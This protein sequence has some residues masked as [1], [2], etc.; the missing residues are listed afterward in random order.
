[1]IIG[2]HIYIYIY[3]YVCVGGFYRCMHTMWLHN[4]SNLEWM[5]QGKSSCST[6]LGR[7]QQ[8]SP[9]AS[10]PDHTTDCTKKPGTGLDQEN[11]SGQ[12]G[13]RAFKLGPSDFWPWTGFPGVPKSET[14]TP[15]A[16]ALQKGFG[17]WKGK[18]LEMVEQNE[19]QNAWYS[20]HGSTIY[21][22]TISVN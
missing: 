6:W 16:S 9:S 8:R 22:S 3:I 17:Q 12:V 21:V 7:H 2:L 4:S 13:F 19:A 20:H 18:D 14:D 11:L 5:M 15:A 1:M 10:G